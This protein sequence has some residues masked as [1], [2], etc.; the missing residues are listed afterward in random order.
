M[1]LGDP[2]EEYEK[3]DAG[4]DFNKKKEIDQKCLLKKKK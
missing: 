1:D 3:G 2:I 4:A